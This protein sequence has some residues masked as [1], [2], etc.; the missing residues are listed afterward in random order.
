MPDTSDQANSAQA[1]KRPRFARELETPQF[2]LPAGKRLGAVLAV[3]L[4]PDGELFL[5][6]QPNAQGVRPEEDAMDCWL[7]P[8]VRIGADG[9]FIEAWGGPDQVPQA[10]GISQWPSKLEAIECDAERNVWVFGWNSDDNAVLK[11]SASGEL[12]LRIGQRGKRGD[13][14]DRQYL[15]AATGCYHDIATREVFFSDGYGNSRV[16]A[17]NSDTGEFTRMWGKNGSDPATPPAEDSYTD[18]VHKIA[19]GPN[20]KFYVADR[21][22]CLVQEF[23]LVPGGARFLR[24]V[25]IAPGTMVLFTGSVWDIGFSPDGQ[26]LYVGDGANMRVWI[27]DLETFCILG[28]TTVHTEYE[29]ERNEPLHFSL[30]HRFAVEPSGDILLACVNRGL[31][32]L[33][34]LGTR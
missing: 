17:F 31:L 14:G 11:F 10:D 13:N 8:V 26:F 30:L 34:Y 23:E 20:G 16:I 25:K 2:R 1:R 27:V 7:P 5:L 21:T 29:N 33:K 32:R 22:G 19:R 9:A 4:S 12:L 3:A 15:S 24:E 6:Q 18:R 28:S